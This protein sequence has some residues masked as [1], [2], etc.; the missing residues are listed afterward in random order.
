MLDSGSGPLKKDGNLDHRL[1]WTCTRRQP[2]AESWSQTLSD[3]GAEV[4]VVN[5][6]GFWHL[7]TVRVLVDEL[8]YHTK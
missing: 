3:D 1:V 2:I 5:P 7:V 4:P 6:N 8:S